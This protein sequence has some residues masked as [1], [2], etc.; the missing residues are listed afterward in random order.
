MRPAAYKASDLRGGEV[1][2]VNLLVCE[3]TDQQRPGFP[4]IMLTRAFCAAALSF[5][6]PIEVGQQ[7]ID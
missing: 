7:L 5:Q 3:N 6:M 4:L 2:P 1:V